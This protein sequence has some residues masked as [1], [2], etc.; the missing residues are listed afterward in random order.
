MTSGNTPEGGKPAD[1]IVAINL[2]PFET[3]S[4]YIPPLMHI[5]MGETTNLLKELKAAII[6]ADSLENTSMKLKPIQP[7]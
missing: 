5:I 6:K 7:N 4:R 3:M 1:T 2:M